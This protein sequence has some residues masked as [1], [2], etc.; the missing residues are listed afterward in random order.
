MDSSNLR[1]ALFR[2][3][4]GIQV[5]ILTVKLQESFVAIQSE[6]EQ[7]KNK[8]YACPPV[9]AQGAVFD[10]LRQRWLCEHRKAQNSSKEQVCVHT[11]ETKNV[12]VSRHSLGGMHLC[13]HNSCWFMSLAT[14]FALCAAMLLSY[15]SGACPVHSK[16]MP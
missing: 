10:M 8:V 6:L 13:M 3:P 7:P 9:Q 15:R 5:R 11:R 1:S 4:R 2:R 12:A 16:K 14:L